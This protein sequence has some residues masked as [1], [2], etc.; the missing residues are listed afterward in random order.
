MVMK[1]FETIETLLILQFSLPIFLK[2]CKTSIGLY[3]LCISRAYFNYV[4]N[5]LNRLH[6]G[7]RTAN[8]GIN[9]RYLKN[10]ADV[11]DKLCCRHT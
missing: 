9:E 11:A 1:I 7:L 6:H 5:K 2:M 4:N 3:I 8:E 10:W